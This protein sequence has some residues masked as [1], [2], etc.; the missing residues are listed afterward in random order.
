MTGADS[1]LGPDTGVPVLRPENAPWLPGS[2]TNEGPE[3]QLR[4]KAR[5]YADRAL[6]TLVEIMENKD[7][8]ASA[9][10]SAAQE[11][12]T[13]GYGRPTQAVDVTAQSYDMT[14]LHLAALKDLV[15]ER[16]ALRA[17]NAK[18]ISGTI[19]GTND[20]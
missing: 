14:A 9:R 8:P 18:T 5:P 19:A 10:V 13:R 17:M 1:D 20:G 3:K 12:L 11:V 4:R 15:E 6:T 16:K 2:Q 7:A